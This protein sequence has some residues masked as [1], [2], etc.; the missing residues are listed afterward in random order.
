MVQG[1]NL[2]PDEIRRSWRTVRARRWMLAA[3]I[4]YAAILVAVFALQ[5]LSI[6]SASKDIA[7]LEAKRMELAA[8]SGEYAALT[9]RLG[10]IQRAEAELRRRYSAAV[11]LAD[12]RV[13]WSTILKRLSGD[14]PRGV[15][16]R[17]LA[18]SDGQGLD[19]RRIRFTGSA[20][21]HKGIADFIFILENAGYFR[22]VSLAFSQ[23][24]DQDSITVYDFEISAAIRV[25]EEILYE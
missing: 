4:A 3:A 23:K 17:S 25:S 11:G 1:I 2:I 5:R 9:A 18:T 6:G 14:L 24:R 12:R 20:T 16:L 8:K 7:A 22:D 21:A 19:D 13:S 10:E 15:W